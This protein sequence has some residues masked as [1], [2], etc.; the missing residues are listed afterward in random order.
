MK[1]WAK[2]LNRTF[3]K[4]EVQMGKTQEEMIDIPGHKE[5][6]NQNHFKNLLHSS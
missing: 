2:E 4:K 3:S 1:K 6:E 5:N